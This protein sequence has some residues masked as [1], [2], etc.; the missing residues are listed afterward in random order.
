MLVRVFV[1]KVKV[2]LGGFYSRVR[3]HP[4]PTSPSLSLPEV[5]DHLLRLSVRGQWYLIEAG[6]DCRLVKEEVKNRDE[7]VG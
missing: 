6:G 7:Y 4:H 1:A 3:L 2:L 5:H